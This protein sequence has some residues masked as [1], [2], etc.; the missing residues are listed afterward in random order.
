M[1]APFLSEITGN[2]HAGLALLGVAIGIG[3]VGAKF[4]ESVGRNPGAR[5]T[6][7]VF[8]ILSIALVESIFFYALFLVK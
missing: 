4:V 3:L 2:L 5:N 1:I 7:L 6:V 8:A